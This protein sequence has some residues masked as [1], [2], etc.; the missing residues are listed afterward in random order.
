MK[1]SLSP[2][3]LVAL[4]ATLAVSTS[5]SAVRTW[6]GDSGTNYDWTTS[7]NWLVA[8]PADSSTTDTAFFG[9]AATTGNRTPNL[10]GNRSIL[11]VTFAADGYTLG[12]TG[13]FT[14]TV[15]NTGIIGNATDALTTINHNV[16][17]LRTSSNNSINLSNGADLTFGTSAT[18]SFNGITNFNSTL[19]VGE[20]SVLTMN[21][22]IVADN[23]EGRDSASRLLKSGLGTWRINSANNSVNTGATG[24]ERIQ[25]TA[26]TIE[27]GASGALGTAQ[28]VSAPTNA[29]NKTLL[30]TTAGSVTANKIQ[31]LD[32]GAGAVHTIGGSNTS[33]TVTYDSGAVN[34]ELSKANPTGT[35]EEQYTKF[36][37]AT[38]GRVEFLSNIAN[39]NNNTVTNPT[40][41]GG[42]DKIGAGTV[43]F[44]GSNTYTLGTVVSEGTL[45]LNNT[46]VGGSGVGSGNL[47][48][49]AG[50]TLGGSGGR[51]NLAVDNSIE[52]NGTIAV[53]DGNA[54]A[55]MFFN[56]S[57]AGAFNL[58]E[59][60][61]VSLDIW[62]NTVSGVDRIVTQGTTDTIIDVGATL[63]VNNA[64]D[65][66]FSFGNSFNLFDWVG[67]SPIGTFSLVLPTL[68]GGLSWDTSDL[69]VGGSISVVPEPSS[70]ALAGLGL[71][72][73]LHLAHRRRKVS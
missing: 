49:N 63:L 2:K 66:T 41:Q 25:L 43:V 5:F 56:T 68:T 70:I 71:F 36:T 65:L 51:V 24:L 50:A 15:G 32:G 14:L 40:R 58:N 61:T 18:V 54:A 26:G 27:L 42:V 44:T 3:L 52:I 28:I 69:Y 62:T 55:I 31:F 46:A 35:L 13:G 33:G 37:A 12:S 38:G 34:L 19:T 1:L 7:G 39:N 6:D 47:T 16:S 8:V 20:G 29:S 72:V 17:F 4:S 30:M 64:G 45:L 22:A 60:S 53:G 48:V 67:G 11:G 73:V 59:T 21:G 57:G 9:A 10:D 23:I